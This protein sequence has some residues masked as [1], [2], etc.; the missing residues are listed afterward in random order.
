MM[1]HTIICI[2]EKII[3]FKKIPYWIYYPLIG[4]GGFFIGDV[5]LRFYG[6]KQY[7]WTQ[8][9]FASCIGIVPVIII[10]ISYS[11]QKTLRELSPM[12]WE[13]QDDFKSW[14]QR[15]AIR[16]FS[17]SSFPSK[18]ITLFVIVTGV[19]TIFAIG[20]PFKLQIV[21]SLAVTAFL[22]VLFVCGQCAYMLLDLLVTLREV[23]QRP[24]RFPFFLLFHPAIVNLQNFYSTIAIGV[25]LGYIGLIFALWYGPYG[26]RFEMQLWLTLLAF[27][28]L[29][30]FSWS[31]LQIHNLIKSIKFTHVQAI[32]DSLQPLVRKVSENSDLDDLSKIEKVMS[33]Q[34]KVQTTSEWAFDLQGAATFVITLA[35]AIVQLISIIR[36]VNP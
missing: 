14:L 27:Y 31:I 6:E 23:V 16:I 28:P 11:F 3:L 24:P 12:L 36:S 35:T 30:L 7:Y 29:T 33:I 22:L 25:T 4:L 5:L 8:I 9:L 17:L 19:V 34:T 2:Y 15:R 32:N 21:N 18:A 13:N 1:K 20:F 26:L 10:W